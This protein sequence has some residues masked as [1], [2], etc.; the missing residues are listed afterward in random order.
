MEGKTP[1][2]VE[3]PFIR[4]CADVIVACVTEVTIAPRLTGRSA[5]REFAFDCGDKFS[6]QVPFI[7]KARRAIK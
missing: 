5:L 3:A 2:L 4:T 1:S 6:S 7:Q